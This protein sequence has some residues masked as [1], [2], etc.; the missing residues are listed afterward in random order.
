MEKE[1]IHIRKPKE[2]YTKYMS[3]QK[4]DKTINI[5]LDWKMDFIII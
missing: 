2:N 1:E 5:H 3:T 4:K